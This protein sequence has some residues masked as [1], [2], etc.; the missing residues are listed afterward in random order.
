MDLKITNK[1]ALVTGS[2]A[3]IGKAIALALAQQ[4]AH[5]IINS[6]TQSSVDAVVNELKSRPDVKGK[7]TGIAADVSTKDGE[8]F[9]ADKITELNE[10]LEIL[11]NNVGIFGFG[12]F[13]AVEDDDWEHYLQV[14]L[15][16]SVRLSRRYLKEMLARNSGRV[17]IISSESGVRPIPFTIHY[18]VTKT[19]QIG[20]ARG[21]A[22]L[23]KGTKVTVN[24]VLA[25]PTWTE[26]IEEYITGLATHKN[27]SVEQTASDFFT[28]LEPTSLLQRFIK[29]EEI[30]SIVTFLTSE[31]ASAINGSAQRVEGGIIRAI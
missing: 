16:S 20:L 18:S 17:I 29:S 25:G 26:R 23:T 31:H 1:L 6:R 9:L 8:K 28:E 5:V 14:N 10:P 2:T 30:A 27:K 7:L 11:V 3:G 24:S 22:E 13:F 4:G 12:D 19:A 15:M 21:L